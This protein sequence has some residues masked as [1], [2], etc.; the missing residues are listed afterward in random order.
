MKWPYLN[1]SKFKKVDDFIF[2]S[3]IFEVAL[4]LLA[5][6]LALGLP[7]SDPALAQRM[8]ELTITLDGVLFGFSAVMIG[9][10]LRNSTK[11]SEPK[12]KVSLM[13][14]LCAF[15]SYISSILLAFVTMR[16]LN[17]Q[18]AIFSVFAPIWLTIFG[19]IFSSIYMVLIFIE[20]NFP[21]ENELAKK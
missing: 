2:W 5:I 18:I 8:L 1:V 13:W 4:V 11:I 12:L 14:G 6:I 20:E 17:T 3:I 9:F 21:A 19:A 10:F 16:D 7:V 15:W